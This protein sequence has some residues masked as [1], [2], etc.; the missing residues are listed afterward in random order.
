MD[1]WKMCEYK[2]L[3]MGV[4]P[5][6]WDSPPATFQRRWI[7][8]N[9][10]TLSYYKN[11]SSCHFDIFIPMQSHSIHFICARFTSLSARPQTLSSE[12]KGRS[13]SRL[14]P[15][16]CMITKPQSITHHLYLCL[17][18]SSL[19]KKQQPLVSSSRWKDRKERKMLMPGKKQFTCKGS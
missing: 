7:F 10:T 1:L 19:L 8:I 16:L 3:G 9:P 12:S 4:S 14:I 6:C 2:C 5:R 18:P 17:S 15:L 11:W 13:T